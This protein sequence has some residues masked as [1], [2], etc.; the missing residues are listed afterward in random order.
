MSSFKSFI[1]VFLLTGLFAYAV[2]SAG[3]LIGLNNYS[4]QNIGDDPSLLSYMSS[5][6]ES[7][8]QAHSTANASESSFGNSPISLT[9]VVFIDAIGGIWKTLKVIPMTIWNLTGGMVTKFIAPSQQ[10]AI[11]FGVIGAILIIT[12]I[13]GVWRVISKGE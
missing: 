3:I 1:I 2:I 10:F 12:I 7:L 8:D 4:S 5:I 13:F 11:V 9:S 6:N